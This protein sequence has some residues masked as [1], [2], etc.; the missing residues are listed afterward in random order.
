MTASEYTQKTDRQGATLYL[1]ELQGWLER[2]RSKFDDYVSPTIKSLDLIK[3]GWSEERAQG[4]CEGLRSYIVDSMESRSQKSSD[5]STKMMH[6]KM[7]IE[8][9]KSVVYDMLNGGVYAMMSRNPSG[10]S[11]SYYGPERGL[12]MLGG[13]NEFQGIVQDMHDGAYDGGYFQDD[14][15]IVR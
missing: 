9:G 15:K 3:K 6:L 11:M 7:C 4:Y 2:T 5:P 12:Q 10:G 14:G 8:N 13:R 1:K